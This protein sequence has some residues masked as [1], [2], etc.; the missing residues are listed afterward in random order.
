[1]ISVFVSNQSPFLCV[2]F[3]K[4]RM[5]KT[6]VISR[7]GAEIVDRVDNDCPVG[8][9]LTG[10]SALLMLIKFGRRFHF[11]GHRQDIQ[12]QRLYK[13]PRH[14]AALVRQDRSERQIGGLRLV[15]HHL[16]H[17]RLAPKRPLLA[18]WTLNSIFQCRPVTLVS[19]CFHKLSHSGRFIRFSKSL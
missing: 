6:F 1:M 19:Y 7:K 16:A 9:K 3:S 12:D 5:A 18:A 14:K 13:R 11:L 2:H 17:I 8:G 15:R 4:R 10:R